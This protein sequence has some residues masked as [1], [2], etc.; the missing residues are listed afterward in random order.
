MPGGLKSTTV[1]LKEFRHTCVS[2]GLIMIN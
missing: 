2:E 1:N